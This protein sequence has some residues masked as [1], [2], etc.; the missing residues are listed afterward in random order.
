MNYQITLTFDELVREEMI[1]EVQS[2]QT[3]E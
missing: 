2:C 3:A 1:E